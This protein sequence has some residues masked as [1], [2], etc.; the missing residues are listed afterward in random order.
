MGIANT[1]ATAVVRNVPTMNGNAPN[2]SCNGSQVVPAI[3][4]R[5]SCVMA[6]HALTRRNTPTEARVAAK[7]NAL[8]RRTPRYNQRT[9]PRTAF[10]GR[11]SERLASR[12]TGRSWVKSN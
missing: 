7:R 3:S 11:G 1:R 6:G 9:E 5:P 2:L 4:P 12:Q 8:P 10:G